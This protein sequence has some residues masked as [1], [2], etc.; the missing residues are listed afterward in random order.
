MCSP[1][2]EMI[3]SIWWGNS[4]V[5]SETFAELASRGADRAMET[6]KFFRSHAVRGHK[7]N[8]VSQRSEEHA[9]IQEMAIK[10][11]TQS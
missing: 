4:Q 3:W 8:S 5:Q 10:L 7:I 2:H 9:V 1:C 6:V 11:G